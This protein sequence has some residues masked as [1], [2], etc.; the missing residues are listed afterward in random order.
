[1]SVF[2]EDIE[3][4]NDWLIDNN[5]FI[6]TRTDGTYYYTKEY[7]SIIYFPKDY[8]NDINHPPHTLLYRYKYR[9][10]SIKNPTISDILYVEQLVEKD[11]E[12]I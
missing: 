9:F 11:N 12:H 6:I 8:I 5:Y 2:D 4:N 1:M 7:R 3:I 10:H